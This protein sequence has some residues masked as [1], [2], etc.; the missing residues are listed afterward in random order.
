MSVY[1]FAGG[2]TGGHLYPG[3]AVAQE[4]VNRE[5]DATIV[6]AC[7]SRDIDRQI[8][9][10]LSYVVA[11]QPIQPLPSSL[12]KLWPFVTTYLRSRSMAK[13]LIADLRP[14][15]VLGLGGFA[16]GPVMVQAARASVRRAFLNPD[17]V[18][19]KANQM[20]ARHAEVI[21]TQFESTAEAFASRHR[22]K[23]RCVGCPIRP[24]FAAAF[25]DEASTA[26]ARDEA[27]RTF[28]LHPSRR[29]LLVFGGSLSSESISAALGQLADDLAPLADRWQVLHI[30]HLPAAK[31][32]ET[33][34]RAA[35]MHT[36]TLP[37]CDRMELAYG[38]ADVVLSRGGAGTVA[39]IATAGRA[40]VI[41]PYPH[42]KDQQQK[43]NAA[44]LE[45]ASAAVI[46]SDTKTPTTN[47]ASLREHLLPILRDETTLLQMQQAA[48]HAGKPNAAQTVAKWML[49]ENLHSL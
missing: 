45:H 19:G 32:I 34:L 39:E 49:G 41:M 12:G 23:V 4:L 10:P 11:P 46:V 14:A 37:Y 33:R 25:G 38:A 48:T 21:F 20:L 30:S 16:A 5:P 22:D 27:I 18:P 43:R 26:A 29:T 17:A 40:S 44:A 13:R 42:H 24:A 1:I 35:G 2:G 8:L 3:L 47:A 15:A 31:D 9:S 7:S 6:F 28:H 36:T